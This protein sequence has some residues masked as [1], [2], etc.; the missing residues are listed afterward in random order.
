[1]DL[2]N[3]RIP[4]SGAEVWPCWLARIFQQPT[5]RC[6]LTETP[7]LISF[8]DKIPPLPDRLPRG[9][10]TSLL[11]S[12]KTCPP[13][14][15]PLRRFLCSAMRLLRMRLPT[16]AAPQQQLPR[17][18][19]TRHGSWRQCAVMVLPL[20]GTFEAKGLSSASSCS[21]PLSCGPC[22]IRAAG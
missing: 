5:F 8:Q 14:P 4:A 2:F 11:G 20:Q 6:P 12:P 13:N 3:L 19:V 10:S 9:R 22:S 15:R 16:A 18:P 17:C 21:E 7:R 1:M